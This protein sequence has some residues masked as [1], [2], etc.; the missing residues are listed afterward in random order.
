MQEEIITSAIDQKDTLALLPTGSGKSICYQVPALASE[1]LCL[2]ISPLIALMKDQVQQLRK[3]GITAF[4]IHTG[5]SFKEVAR[6]LE[7]ATDSN[8][9]LL[10]VSPERLQTRLFK[11]YLPSLSISLIA[12]DEAH[13]VSQWGYDFRP[14]YL[15]IAETREDLPGVPVL[16]LT[17]SATPEVQQDIIQQLR[18]TN[19]VTIKGSFAREALSYSCFETGNKPG[20]MLE[21][22]QGVPGCSV[23]YCKSR[24]RTVEVARQL[25]SAG[26]SA[27]YYHA[28]LD[29]EDR[30]ERQQLWMG[31][32]VRVMVSTN[33]FGMGIDKPDVRTVIHYDAPDC[34]EHYYQEAGRAGRDRNKAYAI[35]LYQKTELDQLEIQLEKKYPPL[36]LIQAVY[37]AIANYH[38]IPTGGGEGI[39]YD[40]ELETFC[41]NFQLDRTPT[42]AAIQLLQA[43][44]Y[45]LMNEAMFHPP[46][47]KFVCDR[48]W[49]EI[50]EQQHPEWDELSKTLLRNYEGIFNVPVTIS[51]LHLAQQ[52]R[53]DKEKVREGLLFLHHYGVI[54]YQPQ[55]EC[56]QLT[57]LTPR[58][59]AEY[60][61]IDQQKVQ[62]RKKKESERISHFLKYINT[63]SCRSSYIGHYFGDNDMKACGICDNC[64]EN[65]KRQHN[66][67][68]LQKEI[69]AK[70]SQG[71]FHL[72]EMEKLFD[73][74]VTKD[75][76]WSVI[77]Y[78]RAEQKISI[79]PNGLISKR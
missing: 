70:V 38:Q 44:G 24:K 42:I 77:E 58:V 35:L 40:F 7:L 27:T 28:G 2:V 60:V 43:E 17:A 21:I 64:I 19:A 41:K 5:M 1:G 71:A 6:T 52:L 29:Q 13:C 34:L 57:L 12:V 9:K 23:V 75:Q 8:C 37:Q 55:K 32:Q 4:A 54:K 51:E 79:D 47:A 22:L 49:L 10:Y 25:Q 62:L 14:S 74:L 48:S 36:P 66:T 15:R 39:T 68:D 59:K 73:N 45:I 76:L 78:L 63:N 26:I 46:K 65:K 53:W 67:L 11:D 69:L 18:L 50:L 72:P 61:R 20:K 3:K 31:N 56:P 30:N 33:A 16:A